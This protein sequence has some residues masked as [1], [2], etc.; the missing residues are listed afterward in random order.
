[1]T[2][3][4]RALLQQGVSES[5]PY[6]TPLEDGMRHFHQFVRRELGPHL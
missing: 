1:M 2:A 4:R 5:G 6:Q 3:G